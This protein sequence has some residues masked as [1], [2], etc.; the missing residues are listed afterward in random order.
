MKKCYLDD[1]VQSHTIP[2][3]TPRASYLELGILG[4][5][6]HFEPVHTEGCFHTIVKIQIE[7]CLNSF[8]WNCR[9]IYGP[10]TPGQ[11]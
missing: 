1:F 3:S 9:F 4:I 2:D 11:L 8:E 10:V 6:I 7:S 5:R